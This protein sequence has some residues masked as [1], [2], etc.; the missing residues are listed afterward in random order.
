M[1]PCPAVPSCCLVSLHFLCY[2]PC[3]HSVENLEA[4]MFETWID[5]TVTLITAAIALPMIRYLYWILFQPLDL[6][7]SYA[8]V[9]YSNV[10]V[11]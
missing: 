10:K 9:G 8:D 4:N 3:S 1:L 2:I 11:L 7:R 5:G 6:R